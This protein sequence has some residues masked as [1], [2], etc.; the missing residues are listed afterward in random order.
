MATRKNTAPTGASFDVHDELITEAGALRLVLHTLLEHHDAPIGSPVTPEQSRDIG[1]CVAQ[2]GLAVERL[3]R[4][5]AQV[6]DRRDPAKRCR[7]CG[8]PRTLLEQHLE[9]QQNALYRVQS[10]L[11]MT[12]AQILVAQNAG[13]SGE[14]SVDEETACRVRHT[15]ELLARSIESVA[16]GVDPEFAL[17]LGAQE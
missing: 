17:K 11:V 15:L 2:L 1:I 6:D 9:E 12:A 16:E 7:P 3:E 5:A 8:A 10:V 4:L 13:E 14:A